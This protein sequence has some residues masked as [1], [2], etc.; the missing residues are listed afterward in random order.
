MMR[1]RQDVKGL[2]SSPCFPSRFGLNESFGSR[3][4]LWI[5]ATTK[6]VSC[7]LVQ[8]FTDLHYTRSPRHQSQTHLHH[9]QSIFWIL[10]CGLSS[11]NLKYKQTSLGNRV[12]MQL[13]EDITLYSFCVIR[14]R[15]PFRKSSFN[16]YTILTILFIRRM[17]GQI[18]SSALW[19][20]ALASLNSGRFVPTQANAGP[21][22]TPLRWDEEQ[23]ADIKRHEETRAHCASVAKGLKSVC[24]WRS[25]VIS[26]DAHRDLPA[27]PLLSEHLCSRWVVW[28]V[29]K[30]TLFQSCQSWFKEAQRWRVDA[31]LAL[32]HTASPL[33]STWLECFTLFVWFQLGGHSLL[34]LL[35]TLRIY[36]DIYYSRFSLHSTCVLSVMHLP[37]KRQCTK[38]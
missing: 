14:T 37:K 6:I 36:I 32:F 24:V 31:E 9:L 4:G 2:S 16:T 13:W 1:S 8:S 35:S 19:D 3:V 5:C 34:V 11:A 15:L 18:N 12:R 26:Q 10:L 22:Q 17:K 29:K 38:F 25:P 7:S 21:D 27:C 30:Y 28:K 20:D 23:T 33:R